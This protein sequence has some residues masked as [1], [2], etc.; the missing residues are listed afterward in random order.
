[1]SP[2]SPASPRFRRLDVRVRRVMSSEGGDVVDLAVYCPWEGRVLPLSDCARC[3]SCQTI[4]IDPAE[5]DS[6]LICARGDSPSKPAHRHVPSFQPD[7]APSGTFAA[8][9]TPVS[10]VM[11]RSVICV[12]AD[13]SI[14]SVLQFLLTKQLTAVPVVDHA[15]QP[16]GVLS[17][18]DLLNELVQRGETRE[19]S[20]PVRL[21]T[22][23]GYSLELG[24]GFHV[25][26]LDRTTAGDVM[27]PLVFS[28]PETATLSEASALMAYE[29]VHRLVVVSRDNKVV[30]IVSSMDVLRWVARESGYILPLDP[31]NP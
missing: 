8:R 30:G 10:E 21:Q 5:R 3:E 7:G 27:T 2:D 24:P 28:V 25:E 20:P 12:H 1:M 22:K 23:D 15:G 13:V 31:P 29:G 11:T 4:S 16:I 9:R 14:E 19:E 26:S 18:T 6:F 17:K